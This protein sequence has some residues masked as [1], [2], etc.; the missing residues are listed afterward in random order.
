Q[1]TRATVLTGVV[2]RE[3][4]DDT[5]ALTMLAALMNHPVWGLQQPLIDQEKWVTSAQASHYFMRDYGA[6]QITARLDPER[7]PAVR[8]FLQ[9]Y[10]VG[11]NPS[12]IPS[13]I[14]EDVRR[15]LL[16]QEA[17]ERATY[18][19]RA[20][21]LGF[22]A[23]RLGTKRA[24]R[25]V[26]MLS[27]VTPDEVAEAAARHISPRKLVTVTV[28][29]EGFDPST[30]LPGPIATA[31]AE[32][33]PQPSL[34]R[35]GL[36]KPPPVDP[37]AFE[38]TG[39]EDGIV[40]FRFS[41]GLRLLVSPSDASRV[42]AASARILGGQWVE[43]ASQAGIN[44]FVSELG[45][46]ATRSF[47]QS[48]LGQLLG[49]LAMTATA[50]ASIGSRAN[51]SRNVDY[52]DSAGRHL[53]GT[54]DTWREALTILKETTFFPQ[55]DPKEMSKVREDLLTEIRTL[56]E[57][58]LEYIKQQFY[59]SAFE[60]HPYGRP[61]VG[62]EESISAISSDDLAAFHKAHWTADRVV[63]TLVGD[64]DPHHA[65]EW[66]AS[67]W[68]DVPNRR[69]GP[70]PPAE[71]VDWA[72]SPETKVIPLGKD[73]WTVNWGRPGALWTDADQIPSR[74]LSRMAG[75]DHFYKY[76]YGEGVSYRSWIRF[77]EARGPGMWIIEN[78]V[79]RERFDE[80]LAMFE[81]DLVRYS[82]EGLPRKNFEDAVM[83]LINSHV[84]SRQDNAVL[85]WRLAVAE[86]NG[87]FE[88][89]TR[90]PE[91]L[92]AVTFQ[93]VSSLA[94]EVFA[95]SAILRMVQQ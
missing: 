61:T 49:S 59:V 4:P 71:T 39:R 47:D 56:P 83:R 34:Q 75:N 23:S 32:D 22:L 2:T 37:L 17:R 45:L 5:A 18:A 94:A 29:P 8:A 33:T 16:A 79:K 13:T 15:G 63:V 51:T 81:E 30:A 77:W 69:A 6:F 53:R 57:N 50:H 36:L 70:L 20:E 9:D 58:N 87:G 12:A 44:R 52:R 43:P 21:R 10:L 80:I 68:A 11:F 73:Y 35:P 24:N 54:A 25:W 72:P 92:R 38:E 31:G 90:A 14:F 74:V 66:L 65:A 85:A 27:L 88:S 19:D 89:Y 40:R 76:V 82:E 64:V 42:L 28:Y 3:G 67:H 55:F 78:D 60:G 93:Q 86:G 91:N 48:E 41:N 95:P 62:T 7:G 84:L 1:A 26:R 46:R